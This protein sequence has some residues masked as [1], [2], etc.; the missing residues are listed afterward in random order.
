MS[1]KLNFMRSGLDCLFSPPE[2]MGA[3]SDEHGESFHHDIS[4]K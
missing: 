4:Q 1:L 2:N 3:V